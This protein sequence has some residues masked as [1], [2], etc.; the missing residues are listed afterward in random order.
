MKHADRTLSDV[1]PTAAKASRS[2]ELPAYEWFPDGVKVE[3][4]LWFS[5]DQAKAHFFGITEYGKGR[6]CHSQ[7]AYAR[8]EHVR[9]VFSLAELCGNCLRMLRRRALPAERKGGAS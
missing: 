6:L 9:E 4:G 1:A 2:R 3:P 8:G 7:Q 5:E